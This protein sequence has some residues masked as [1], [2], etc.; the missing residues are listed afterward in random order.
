MCICSFTKS[1]TLRRL[2]ESKLSILMKKN[3]QWY[4]K[5]LDLIPSI[6]Y[7]SLHCKK[8]STH[9]KKY[10]KKFSTNDFF[11]KCDQIC[12]FLR[13]WSYLL[14]KS[15]IANVIFCAVLIENTFIQYSK[16]ESCIETGKTKY[17]IYSNEH[18]RRSFNFGF[19]NGGATSEEV[20]FRG[21][22]SLK[23]SNRHQNTFNSFLWSNHKNSNHNRR[24]KFLMFKM[25]CK[26]S[27]FTKVKQSSELNQLYYRIF[28]RNFQISAPLNT[29]FQMSVS[30]ERISSRRRRSLNI[31]RQ[32]G[33][34]GANSR[35]PLFRVQALFRVNTICRYRVSSHM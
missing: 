9:C 18:P 1:L 25:V 33:G 19:S 11:S 17:R 5:Q 31:L 26:R 6:K 34:K 2:I 35:E 23:I 16:I 22:R 15:L 10:C 12:S 21:K 7:I 29:I 14:K 13:I 4:K 27:L 32:K 8:Y 28:L 24:I 20:L 30:F 3:S